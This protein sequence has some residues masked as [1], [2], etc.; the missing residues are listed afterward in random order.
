M[1]QDYVIDVNVQKTEPVKL[2]DRTGLELYDY[3][4]E[5]LKFFRI[6][7]AGS[8]VYDTPTSKIII[9]E[10]GEI[11]VDGHVYEGV[12]DKS[13]LKR[14]FEYGGLTTNVNAT[15]IPRLLDIYE[16]LDII[17]EIDVAKD[18]QVKGDAS[19][20]CII[21]SSGGNHCAHLINLFEKSHKFI[22]FEDSQSFVETINRFLN[23]DISSWIS[24]SKDND[25]RIKADIKKQNAELFEN[26]KF[27]DSQ[28]RKITSN[29]NFEYSK[30]LQDLVLELHI[31]KENLFGKINS[32]SKSI[33]ESEEDKMSDLGYVLGSALMS[34][35][36]VKRGESLWVS[37]D[38][39]LSAGDNELIDCILYKTN[40]HLKLPKRSL[41][42]KII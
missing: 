27:L 8:I 41:D 37:A 29:S 5:S 36:Q 7:E 30:E 38:E 20:R 12:K 23:V 25:K 13:S 9:S 22:E 40:K 2:K 35:S 19:K 33:N 17:N 28:I 24:G 11:S 6:N 32:N 1:G 39:Y 31:E 42:V 10:S 4:L 16:N 18:L 34:D 14:F 26:I 3:L 15:Y 21:V